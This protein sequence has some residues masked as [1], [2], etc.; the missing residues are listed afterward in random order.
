MIEKMPPQ[1]WTHIHPDMDTIYLFSSV[2]EI[3]S[4]LT[5]LKVQ[6]TL[7]NT[8]GYTFDQNDFCHPRYGRYVIT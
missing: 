4:N 2:T 3:K 5:C 7:V 1:I 6:Y 8:F